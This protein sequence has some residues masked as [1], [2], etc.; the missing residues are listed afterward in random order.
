ME[1]IVE[2]VF[3]HRTD[4]HLRA[5][6]KLLNGLRHD[7]CCVMP[8]QIDC[9]RILPRDDLD[10]GIIIDRPHQIGKLAVKRYCHGLLGQG[11]RNTLGHV[12]AGHAGVKLAHGLI[13]E[14]Q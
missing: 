11:F 1:I 12:A 14:C 4:R 9:A 7:M 13:G 3:D 2:A 10:A 8:D 5:G 6:K